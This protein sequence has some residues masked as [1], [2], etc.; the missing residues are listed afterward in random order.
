MSEVMYTRAAQVVKAL[1]EHKWTLSAAE[2]CTGGWFSKSIVD[3]GG[4]SAVFAGS[5]VSYASAVKASVLSVS[6]DNLDRYTA[7]SGPVAEEM[8]SGVR[9]L[10]QTDLAISVTGL[11]GPDGGS[12]EIPVGRVYIAL[13]DKDQSRAY[14]YDFRGTRDEVRREAVEEMHRLLINYIEN[15]G[16]GDI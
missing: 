12:E 15:K 9:R 5:V 8:A 13:A 3:I 16:Q 4:A 6:Q 2:S 10:M 1:A 7:V 14:A 11:A